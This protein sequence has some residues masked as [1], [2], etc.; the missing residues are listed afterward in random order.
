MVLDKFSLIQVTLVYDFVF[1]ESLQ[2]SKLCMH[3]LE[4]QQLSFCISLLTV[5][6]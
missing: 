5:Y 1:K 4:T 2:E 6:R 3:T